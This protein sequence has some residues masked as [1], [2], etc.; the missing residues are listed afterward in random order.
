MKPTPLVFAGLLGLFS[1]ASTAHSATTYR[2]TF[3][4]STATGDKTASFFG[5]NH[6]LGTGTGDAATDVSTTNQSWSAN[7]NLGV[8]GGETAVNANITGTN[9]DH[10]LFGFRIGGEVGAKDQFL[11]STG[12]YSPGSSNL[13]E[14]MSMNYW[15]RNAGS[16]IIRFAIQVGDDWYVSANT[17]TATGQT[18]ASPGTLTVNFATELWLGISVSSTTLTATPSGTAAA[19]A[20]GTV[21]GF[22]FYGDA[23]TAQ[24]ATQDLRMDDFAVSVTAI[25]EP[26]SYAALVGLGAL[27]LV[28]FRRRSR[29]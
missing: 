28:A 4:S 20:T 2:E 21:N 27:G 22:G 29:A 26:S 6:L 25:P 13:L 1:F 11:I 15:Q 7:V 24:G 10:G 14:S 12:E 18:Q 8:N 16:S 19:L 23:G 5:W 17:F 9:T 3:Q